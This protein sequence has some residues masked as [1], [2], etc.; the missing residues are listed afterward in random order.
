MRLSEKEENK[1][2]EEVELEEN[3]E[4]VEPEGGIR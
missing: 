1:D 2:E 4:V 3:G